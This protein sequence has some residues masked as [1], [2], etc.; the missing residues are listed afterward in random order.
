MPI[1]ALAELA[2]FGG[3]LLNNPGPVGA[4]VPSSPALARRMAGFLP[5]QP[6]GYVIELGAGT[7]AI[8]TALLERGLPPT[9]LIPIERSPALARHLRRRF[10]E[11]NVLAGDA[12]K[13]RHLIASH[14]NG[15]PVS[16]IVSSLPLR[17][18]PKTTVVRILREIRHLLAP[19]SRFIQYTYDL[20]PR[21]H[22]AMRGFVRC[23]SSVVWLNFPPARVDVFRL[24][25][26]SVGG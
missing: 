11:L 22:R 25:G 10:P 9:R 6:A 20:R 17:S 1:K 3:E 12:A 5:H 23:G 15:L 24:A 7:G 19:D 16:H 26:A 8:T 2:V 4:A 13:L 18:L 14:L 21:T